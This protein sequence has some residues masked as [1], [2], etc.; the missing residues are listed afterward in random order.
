MSTWVPAGNRASGTQVQNLHSSQPYHPPSWYN[1][2]A[3]EAEV[4]YYLYL[5]SSKYFH[6]PS[7]TFYAD[8][9]NSWLSL[10][11]EN[12]R[13]LKFYPSNLKLSWCIGYP[14]VIL[15]ICC[16]WISM[17]EG[18]GCFVFIWLRHMYSVMVCLLFLVMPLHGRLQY[19][20]WLWLF[21]DIFYIVYQMSEGNWGLLRKTL[22]LVLLNKL[23]C[24]TH[25]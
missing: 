8:L 4:K 23:R 15:T 21:L 18:A 16:F 14:E 9:S 7:L 25:F 2:N 1:W 11:L 12:Y 10:W 3:F 19:V 5:S 22:T 24:H 17:V 20:L 13:C 6:M